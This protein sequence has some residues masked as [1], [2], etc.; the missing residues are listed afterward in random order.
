MDLKNPRISEKRRGYP[1]SGSRMTLACLASV[2]TKLR[3]AFALTLAELAA[4]E[5]VLAPALARSAQTVHEFQ[6]RIRTDTSQI[7]AVKG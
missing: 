7:Q 6:S 2:F 5:K 1:G 4:I 3:Q